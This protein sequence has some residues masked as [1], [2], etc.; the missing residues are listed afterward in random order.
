MGPSAGLIL[1]FSMAI[2]CAS[3]RPSNIPL[4]LRS[5]ID[6]FFGSRASLE[7]SRQRSCVVTLAPFGLSLGLK[8]TSVISD[9]QTVAALM[10][11]GLSEDMA[12]AAAGNPTTLR[13]ALW[14]FYQPQARSP[15]SQGRPT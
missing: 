14:Q 6:R 8:A 2:A 11:R 3:S 10:N 15:S 9:N 12:R 13:A 7:S 5:K 1:A 4:P